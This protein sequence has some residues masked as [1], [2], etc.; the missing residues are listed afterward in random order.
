MATPRLSLSP[1]ATAL[2]DHLKPLAPDQWDRHTTLTGSA[3]RGEVAAAPGPPPVHPPPPSAAAGHGA[4]RHLAA[5]WGAAAGAA[6]DGG[7]SSPVPLGPVTETRDT[8][9]PL[10]PGPMGE[11]YHTSWERA[12]GEVAAAPGPP[13]GPPPPPSAASRPLCPAPPLAAL[14]HHH[15]LVPDPLP[16]HGLGPASPVPAGPR[17]GAATPGP[18]PA[19]P[20]PPSAA[21]RP[22]YPAPPAALRHHHVLVPD[23]L[24]QHR[25]GLG[26]PDSPQ[27]NRGLVADHPVL[28]GVCE[29]LGQGGHGTL[30]L[31]LGKDK[32]HLVAKDRA[33]GVLDQGLGQGTGRGGAPE[34]AEGK[35][36][37]VPFV[38]LLVCLHQ[39][40]TKLRNIL[41]SCARPPNRRVPGSVLASTRRKVVCRLVL[42]SGESELAGSSKVRVRTFCDGV[43]AQ[44]LVH[45]LGPDRRKRLRRLMSHHLILALIVQHLP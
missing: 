38:Q 40:L 10:L 3:R 39:F 1:L 20:P 8:P 29:A 33:G 9:K 25:L 37:H 45:T 7:V 36:G 24:P 42:Q 28:P 27:R 30:L 21:S 11:A 12:P 5:R 32:G 22:P 41:S 19:P 15:V 31:K 17:P 14:R 2:A 18:P 23:P 34:V 35:H 44:V 43:P 4:Q 26:R 16:Q 13:P 6:G